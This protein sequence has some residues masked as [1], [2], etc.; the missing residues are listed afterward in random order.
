MKDLKIIKE[1]YQNEEKNEYLIN[2]KIDELPT[3]FW[4]KNLDYIQ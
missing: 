3:F 1:Q 2:Y 4:Y